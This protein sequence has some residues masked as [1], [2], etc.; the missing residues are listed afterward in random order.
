MNY[1]GLLAA[2]GRL[3]DAWDVLASLES[4]LREDSSVDAG[5]RERVARMTLG[6][7]LMLHPEDTLTS[8]DEIA[9]QSA[10]LASVATERLL[11]LGRPE[12]AARTAG[13]AIERFAGNETR[14]VLSVLCNNH[15]VALSAL[16]RPEE[17]VAVLEADAP[18]VQSQEVTDAYRLLFAGNYARALA[19]V[20]R[21]ERAIAFLESILRDAQVPQSAPELQR[22]RDTLARLRG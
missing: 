18:W 3:Q 6:V 17:A 21:E 9:V 1:G 20:G 22:A 16:G 15:S 19:R 2:A 14:R 8:L 10:T 11:E 7:Y 12:H 4:R 13:A 5:E